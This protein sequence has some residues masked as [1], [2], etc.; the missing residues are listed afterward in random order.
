[1]SVRSRRLEDA[2]ML[3]RSDLAASR[4]LLLAGAVLLNACAPPPARSGL[5]A[6]PPL[7]SFCTIRLAGNEEILIARVSARDTTWQELANV[8]ELGGRVSAIVGDTL[9]V[10]PY[11]LTTRAPAAGETTIFRGRAADMPDLVLVPMTADV[12]IQ[13]FRT[14]GAARRRL[15]FP[16]VLGGLFLLTVLAAD[17]ALLLSL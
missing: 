6:P 15:S 3:E 9:L 12:S 4:R 13:E 16:L 11:Y 8:L 2:L 7:R 14:P 10:Q 5:D 17:A 1:M